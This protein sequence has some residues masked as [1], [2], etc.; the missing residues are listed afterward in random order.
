[1]L[2]V[3][4]GALEPSYS[5]HRHPWNPK[6][7]RSESLIYGLA[8][9]S[10]THLRSLLLTRSEKLFQTGQSPIWCLG[11]LPPCFWCLYQTV[12]QPC[13]TPRHAFGVY[14]TLH[15]WG[16]GVKCRLKQMVRQPPLRQG[17]GV[18]ARPEIVEVQSWGCLDIIYFIESSEIKSTMKKR[19][20]SSR[21][22]KDR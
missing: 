7:V 8:G 9:R 15:P 22:R 20:I 16:I 19:D 11:G 14:Q 6:T 3:L 17:L 12:H 10:N 1:M 18:P 5:I 4:F 21:W 2:S 13:C